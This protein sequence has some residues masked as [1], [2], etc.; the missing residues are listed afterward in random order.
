[1]I[2]ND[3]IELV[4]N[5]EKS[6]ENELFITHKASAFSFPPTVL[7]LML[8][9]ELSSPEVIYNETVAAVPRCF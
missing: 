9:N 3:T 2:E 6:S 8:A 4:G 7:P 5:I 1:M